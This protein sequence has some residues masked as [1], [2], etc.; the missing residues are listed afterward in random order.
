MI[1]LLLSLGV[2]DQNITPFEMS[3]YQ[4]DRSRQSSRDSRERSPTGSRRDDR[5]YRDDRNRYGTH[6]DHRGP[7]YGQRDQGRGQSRGRGPPL[8]SGSNTRGTYSNRGSTSYTSS[9]SEKL[10]DLPTEVLIPSTGGKLKLSMPIPQGG[11]GQSVNLLVNHFA[12]QS[13]PTIKVIR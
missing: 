11:L 4:D 6:N 12:L 10:P 3:G 13:L 9:S 1:D 7:Q 5:S 8:Y 2:L